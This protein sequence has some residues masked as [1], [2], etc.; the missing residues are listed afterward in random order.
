MKKLLLA[1]LIAATSTAALA[2]ASVVMKVKGKMNHASC[3]PETEQ[4]W[5]NRLRHHCAG[6]A[7]T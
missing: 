3:T 7:V 6:P 1:A 5:L 4:R 2:D